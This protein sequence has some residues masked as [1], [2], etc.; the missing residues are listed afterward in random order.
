MKLRNLV[1]LVTTMTLLLGCYE[2]E[3]SC[4]KRLDEDFQ[5][6]RDYA[7]GA[8]CDFEELI[9][10]EMGFAALE[11]QIRISSIYEDDD[12]DACDYISVGRFL[13]RK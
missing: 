5:I 4:Y 13:R 1:L 2:S 11:S 3:K 12:Q 7:K 10:L 6:L 9:C 8:L